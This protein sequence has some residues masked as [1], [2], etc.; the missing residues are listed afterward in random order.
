MLAFN[1]VGQSEV[2]TN[3]QTIENTSGSRI[4]FIATGGI[5]VMGHLQDSHNSNTQYPE[6]GSYG[7]GSTDNLARWNWTGSS[8]DGTLNLYYINSSPPYDLGD[9]EILY[10]IELNIN[11]SNGKVV[12][13]SAAVDPVWAYNGP[14]NIIPSRYAQ[15]GRTYRLRKNMNGIP[16]TMAAAKAEGTSAI[17]DYFS[18][19]KEAPEYEEE[20]T[21]AI[22]NADK[23][24]VTHAL[25]QTPGQTQILL[26]PMSPILET[27]L[28][29]AQ[30]DE[31]S[32][33]ISDIV[34]NYLNIGN[35]QLNRKGPAGILIPSIR[36]KNTL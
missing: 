22:K 14:T 28:E 27:I 3:N 18:A 31:G 20:I 10:F 21:Q 32:K 33:E 16:M 13:M 35:T 26:D 23:D 5:Y 15:D 2:K 1:S 11:N 12:S 19:F 30:H 7:G 8:V 25:S 9:G 29:L 17:A 36:W 34:L 4:N 24:I 6:R